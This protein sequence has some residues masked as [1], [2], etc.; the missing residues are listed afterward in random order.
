MFRV[1]GLGFKG[2]GP[3]EGSRAKNSMTKSAQ[4]DIE[5]L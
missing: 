5:R 2:S 4:C 3:H 1:Q